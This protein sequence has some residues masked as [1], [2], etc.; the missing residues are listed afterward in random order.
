[1]NADHLADAE[2]LHC[3]AGVA[4]D[5]DL[6]GEYLDQS[7]HHSLALPDLASRLGR[8]RCQAPLADQP[9]PGQPGWPQGQATR[10]SGRVVQLLLAVAEVVPPMPHVSAVDVEVDCVAGEVVPRLLEDV[11]EVAVVGDWLEVDLAEASLLGSLL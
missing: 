10:T 9:L 4:L 6:A 1:M 5:Q 2:R 11:G 7:A 3:R 8:Q